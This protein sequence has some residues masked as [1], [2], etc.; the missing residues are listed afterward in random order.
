MTVAPGFPASSKMALPARRCVFQQGDGTGGSE[1][2]LGHAST[3]AQC[4]A[5]VT[6]Q[7]PSANGAT[8]SPGGGSCYAEFGM[9]GDNNS[10][11]WRTCQFIQ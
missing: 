3:E 11:W 5:M 8:V 10:G 4:H 6:A 1:E 9:N 7:R 2:Y